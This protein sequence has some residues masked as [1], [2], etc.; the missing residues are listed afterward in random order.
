MYCMNN[1][2]KVRLKRTLSALEKKKREK[3]REEKKEREQE[4]RRISVESFNKLVECGVFIYVEG[5][6]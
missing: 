1:G 4:A 5:D 3:E 2:R 6:K